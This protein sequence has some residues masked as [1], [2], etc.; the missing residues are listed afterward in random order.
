MSQP[1]LPFGE[2]SFG[3][4]RKLLRAAAA[5]E[6][7]VMERIVSLARNLWPRDTAFHLAA[8]ARTTP[9]AAE[10]WLAQATGMSGEA[11]CGLLRSDAGLRVLEQIMG[12]A[13]PPWWGD[14]QRYVKLAELEKLQ[15]MQDALLAELERD[16]EAAHA[17]T[18]GGLL[19]MAKPTTA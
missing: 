9:R 19:H 18:V 13:R 5:D 3:E 1:Y 12:E 4:P 14:V 10:N 6:R 16:Q 2:R 8:R 15:A 11:V 17:R 7:G